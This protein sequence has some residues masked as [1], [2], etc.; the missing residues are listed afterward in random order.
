MRKFIMKPDIT[1][2]DGVQ[3]NKDT[4]LTYKDDN[5]EQELKD[6]TLMINKTENADNYDS[7]TIL[8]IYLQEGDILLFEEGR[9]Y[10]LPSIP[11]STIKDAVE[12][13]EALKSF[14]E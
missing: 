3:V 4:K 5:V 1:L 10:F 13:L 8:N 2:Y 6:L 7:H 12:D 14:D 9:G 11:M